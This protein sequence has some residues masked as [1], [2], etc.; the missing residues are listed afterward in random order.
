[1][2]CK[3][4]NKYNWVY[5]AVA[6]FEPWTSVFSD[7]DKQNDHFTQKAKSSCALEEENCVGMVLN[8]DGSAAEY[9]S[10]YENHAKIDFED[11][12]KILVF[13]WIFK[14]KSILN[15]DILK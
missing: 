12:V 14:T 6:G 11:P 3:K 15:L 4:C 13:Y 10:K 9:F 2:M 7:L 1:M 5:S 8:W